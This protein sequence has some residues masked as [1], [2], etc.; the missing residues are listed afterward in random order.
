MQDGIVEGITDYIIFNALQNTTNAWSMVSSQTISHCWKKTGILPSNNEVK[1]TFEDFDSIISNSF[2]EEIN[3]FDM[4]I[5][6]LSK[7][8]LNAYE[9]I[10]IKNEIP[11]GGLT[12]KEII[13][14][15]LNADRKDEVIIN[16]IKFTPVLKKVG[17]IAEE[18]TI[19]KTIR[20]LYK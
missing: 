7:S 15:I 8:D 2:K 3:K 16:K 14:T 13:D 6:Q 1:E 10:H 18:K 5:P 20:F 19:N 17:P 4:L 12:D 9:Y 11:E